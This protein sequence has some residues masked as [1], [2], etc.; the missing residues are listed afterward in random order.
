MSMFYVSASGSDV[1]IPK[2]LNPYEQLGITTSTSVADT[3]EVLKQELTQPS[4]QARA[5][6]SLAYHMISSTNRRRY[7]KY[8]TLFE[9]NKPDIFTFAAI[10]HTEKVLEEISRNPR[11]L[12]SADELCRPL[13]YYTSCSGFY[14]TTKALLKRGAKIDQK[15]ADDSTPLHAAAFYGQSSIVKLL[16]VRGAD[17]SLKNEAGNTPVEESSSPEVQQIFEENKHDPMSVIMST[18]TETGLVED[19]VIFISHDGKIVARE[20]LRSKKLLNESTS[21]QWARI[22]E[23]WKL[24]FHGTKYDHIESIL[25]HGFLKSGSKPPQGQRNRLPSNHFQPGEAHC[26][27]HDR[28]EAV[29]VSPSILHA[30]HECYSERIAAGDS[31]WSIVMK[32]Y[33]DP[34]C[35]DA[36]TSTFNLN[37]P[38]I[39]GERDNKEHRH[40]VKQCTYTELYEKWGEMGIPWRESREKESKNAVVQSV[41]FVDLDFLDSVHDNKL[42]HEDVCKLFSH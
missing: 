18:L 41:L 20:V 5:L 36:T 10:G 25:K 27:I 3:K 2:T 26:S 29:F 16:L 6:A 33:I 13:L 19:E 14:D 1:A 39:A 11:L 22:R 7:V 24:A 30:C 42:S 8:G 9:I 21:Y 32:V 23:Q 12:N 4:R 40:I 28:G 15:Q 38:P 17:P 31:K 35:Y 37:K 34:S